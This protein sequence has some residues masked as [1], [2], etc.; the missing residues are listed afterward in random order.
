MRIRALPALISV[1][2]FTMSISLAARTQGQGQSKPPTQKPEEKT[3]PKPDT[4]NVA[5]KWNLMINAASGAMESTLELKADPKDAKKITGSISSQV[6]TAVLEGSWIEGTLK[7]AFTMDV[8][9]NTISVA[10]VG[11]FQKDGSLAGT[12]DFGQG[13]VTWTGT[14]AK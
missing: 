3:E 13:D 7:F 12:L 4:T 5:G 2:A 14:R 8:Q 1:A 11:K 6:G 9:G 10:F